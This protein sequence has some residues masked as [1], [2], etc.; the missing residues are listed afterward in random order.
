MLYILFSKNN[1]WVINNRIVH[2]YIMEYL[3]E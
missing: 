3:T 1:F 2:V